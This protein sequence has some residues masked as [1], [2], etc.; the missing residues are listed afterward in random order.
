[1]KPSVRQRESN[2]IKGNCVQNEE[3]LD[4]S[5]NKIRRH[6]KEREYNEV[7]IKDLIRLTIIREKGSIEMIRQRDMKIEEHLEAVKSLKSENSKLK[8]EIS[9]L[10]IVVE[11]ATVGLQEEKVQITQRTV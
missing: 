10:R 2:Y 8:N 4:E 3:N 7:G 6:W 9:D 5:E 1:M 11:S